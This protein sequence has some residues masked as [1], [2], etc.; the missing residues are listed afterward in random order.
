MSELI[1]QAREELSKGFN[2][3]RIDLAQSLILHIESLEARNKSL[4]EE[5]K[6][7]S[8]TADLLLRRK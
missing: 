5:N 8:A 2:S 6:R 7:L 1:E 4:V 3:F